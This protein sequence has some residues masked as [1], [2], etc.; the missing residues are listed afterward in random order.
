MARRQRREG[1]VVPRGPRRRLI[2]WSLA[3]DERTGRYRAKSK[4]IHGTR[5]DAERELQKLTTLDVQSMIDGMA[6]RA[7]RA[8]SP[9][10]HQ[11]TRRYLSQAL[12]QAVRWSLIRRN[13]AGDDI[14]LPQRADGQAS[15][16]QQDE[17]RAWS[18]DELLA[19]LA[20]AQGTRWESLWLLLAT[21]SCRPG[22]ALGLAWLHLNFDGASGCCVRFAQAVTRDERAR[23]VL[24]PIKTRK[25]R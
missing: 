25:T 9:R 12:R 1:E 6:A 16:G 20:A 3:R 24:G 2:R 8:L 15:A 7:G 18:R 23:L 17:R 11:L 14:V 5:R 21:T 4:T 19:F 13:V 22:E 10:T